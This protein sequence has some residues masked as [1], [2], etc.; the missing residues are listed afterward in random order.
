MKKLMIAAAAAAMIGGAEAVTAEYDFVA[1]LTTTTGQQGK[2]SYAYGAGNDGFNEAGDTMWYNDPTYFGRDVID[3]GT[4]GTKSFTG[5]SW[6]TP[7]DHPG[8]TWSVSKSVGGVPYPKLEIAINE[9]GIPLVSDADAV[10][11]QYLVDTYKW[12]SY[13]YWCGGFEWYTKT[14]KQCFRVFGAD[15]IVTKVYLNTDDC[16]NRNNDDRPRAFYNSVVNLGSMNGRVVRFSNYVD[17]F[18]NRFGAQESDNAIYLE[19]FAVVDN[20]TTY[21]A[22]R[23]FDG[24]LAGQ[25]SIAEIATGTYAPYQIAGNI[26]GYT[27]A[28]ECP[29]C[30]VRPLPKAIAVDCNTADTQR[31]GADLPTA[32]FGT[33]YIQWLKNL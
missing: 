25:G 14:E 18:M 9:D 4:P 12:Q 10:M 3:N 24:Y 23:D 26:V 29:D 20:V 17:G 16:C 2:E 5:R 1:D 21:A 6:A 28:P 30:C 15:N 27:D 19:T 33:F 31:G 32:A 22:K 8:L 7:T 13:G 11:L